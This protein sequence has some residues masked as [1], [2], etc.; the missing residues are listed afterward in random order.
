MIEVYR[1][2]SL[3]A[4]IT[5]LAVL[6]AVGSIISAAT[7]KGSA[8]DRWVPALVVVALSG[9]CL[10]RLARSGVYADE[11]GVRIVNPLRTDRIR[12]EELQ[13]FTLRPHKGFRALGFAERIDGTQVQIWGIQARS[14][15]PA[16]V[17]VPQQLIDELNERLGR[18][19][20]ARRRPPA[21]PP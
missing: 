1:V 19:R 14:S 10:A 16:A 21:P 15:A 2:R 13:R 6:F 12:W 5:V 9:F 11:Q 18:E 20:A 17:R 3:V 8:T 7:R 4:L